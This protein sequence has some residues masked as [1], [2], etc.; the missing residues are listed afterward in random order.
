MLCWIICHPVWRSCNPGGLLM[1]LAT[2]REHASLR[3]SCSWS[4]WLDIWPESP[5][6]SF[7]L[8]W[9]LI[10][11]YSKMNINNHACFRNNAKKMQLDQMKEYMSK[12][13]AYSKWSRNNSFLPFYFL[14]FPSFPFLS[15]SFHPCFMPPY[16]FSVVGGGVASGR[17]ATLPWLDEMTRRLTPVPS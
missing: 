7:S 2:R 12:C 9:G 17:V 4:L 11:S 14:L 13:W 1:R 15:L 6:A 10:P 3:S 5:A 8:L 16:C